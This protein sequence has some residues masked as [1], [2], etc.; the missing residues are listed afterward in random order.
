MNKLSTIEAI[1]NIYENG[2]VVFKGY[3]KDEG[4]SNF[5]LFGSHWAGNLFLR[6][7]EKEN[8]NFNDYEAIPIHDNVYWVETNEIDIN[9]L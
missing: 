1:K 9:K 6:M 5:Y 3:S 8:N 2:E 7:V 4:E